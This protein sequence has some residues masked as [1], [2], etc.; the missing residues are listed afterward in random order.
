LVF[1]TND[2]GEFQVFFEGHYA[3]FINQYLVE[4]RKY[5]PEAEKLYPIEDGVIAFMA[6]DYMTLSEIEERLTECYLE[7][8]IKDD[9]KDKHARWEQL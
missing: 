8:L 5:V 6:R 7:A 4:L 2:D 9:A 3:E 1:D